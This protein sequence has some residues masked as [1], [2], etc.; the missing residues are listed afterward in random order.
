[1]AGTFQTPIEPEGKRSSSKVW[2]IVLV[3]VVLCC[4]LVACGAA[5]YWLWENGDQL[6]ED[7]LAFSSFV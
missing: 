2:L 6:F 7:L 4:L 1:M 3:V 5:G